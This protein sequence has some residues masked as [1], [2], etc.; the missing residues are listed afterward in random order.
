VPKIVDADVWQASGSQCAVKLVIDL[1]AVERATDLGG[2]HQAVLL[3]Q[4]TGM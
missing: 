3:P 4:R 2:E 1:A